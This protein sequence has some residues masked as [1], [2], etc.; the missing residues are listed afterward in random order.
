MT[1]GDDANVVVFDPRAR[2][3]VDRDQLGRVARRTRPTTVA[4]CTGRVRALRR[5]RRRLVVRRRGVSREPTAGD[6]SCSPTAPTFEGY[7]AGHLPRVGDNDGRV[8]LQHR[9]SAAIKR[10]SP[11]RATPVRSLPSPTRTSATT[12][13]RRSTTSRSSVVRRRR[14][15][16]TQR[17]CPR[18]GARSDPLEGLLD[19]P[20]RGPG[21]RRRRHPSPDDATCAR[22]GRCPAPSATADPSGRGG[23]RARAWHRRTGLRHSTCRPSEPYDARRG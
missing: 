21:H 3:T 11:T 20:T 23:R 5:E 7:A 19:P 8:R 14:R 22:T 9:A 15:A 10:S 1:A 4:K 13:S 2:W 12:A 18:T 16:R 17:R 6:Y